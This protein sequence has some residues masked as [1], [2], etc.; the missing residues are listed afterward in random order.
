MALIEEHVDEYPRDALVL[1]LA[2]GVFGLLGF[3]G[4]A[5]FHEAQ[6]A[7]LQR[8]AP[9]WDE[10]W[11]FLTYLGW[12][13]IE[14][15]D[16]ATGAAEVERALALNA[17]N[18]YAAHARAHGYFEAGEADAGTAFIEGWLPDYDRRSQLHAHLSWHQ[19]LFELARGNSARAGALYADAIRPPR[20][21]RR[22]CSISP[23]PRLSCGAGGSIRR[24]RRSTMPGPK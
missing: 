16:I 4:R 15:G 18:A 12:A 7:L 20:R 14:L 23:M 22:R 10:D 24:L 2:L 17:H 5:D 6:L 11:W 3:S 19:A 21:T 9:R 1:S 8:L 13:R